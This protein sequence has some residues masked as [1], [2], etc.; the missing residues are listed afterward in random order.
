MTLAQIRSGKH[1]AFGT[2]KKL[3]DDSVDDACPT[4]QGEPHTLEHWWMRCPGTLAAKHEL[5]GGRDEQGLML[6]TKEPR[7]ALALA[8][9]TLLGAG[10]QVAQ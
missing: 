8:R 2:Y 4:C 9:R 6:L 10:R 7:K 1:R 3:L 5:F